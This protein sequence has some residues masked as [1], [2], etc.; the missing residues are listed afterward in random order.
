MSWISNPK[1]TLNKPFYRRVRKIRDQWLKEFI[2]DLCGE[3]VDVFEGQ[4]LKETL[5]WFIGKIVKEEIEKLLKE[6]LGDG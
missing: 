5:E 1:K 2:A 6:R 3:D 4:T